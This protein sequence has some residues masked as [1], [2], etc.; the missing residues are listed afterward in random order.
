MKPKLVVATSFGVHP[1]KGGGQSRVA[2]L[3]GALARLGVEIEIVS[4]VGR[5]DRDGWIDPA[6]G[7]RELRV[8]RTPEHES[9]DWRLNQLV[10]VPIGDVG[11][12]LNHARTPAYAEAVAAC[13]ADA[14]AVVACHPY[15]LPVLEPLGLPVIYEAQDVEADLKGA[16][17]AETPDGPEL[18][19]QVREVEAACCAVAHHVLVCAARDGARLGELYGVA[20]E[21]VLEV[22][23]GADPATIPFTSLARRR[24]RVREL[25]LQDRMTALFVGS[26]HE[27]NLVAIRDLLQIAEEL[28]EAGVRVL[29]CGSAGLAFADYGIPGNI[30]L[31]GVVDDA[32]LGSLL[33][34]ADVALNPMRSGSGSNLKMLDYALGG[35]PLVSSTFGAR[36]FDVEPGT[37]YLPAEPE[38]LPTVLAAL[39][40]EPFAITETR[41]ATARDHVETR[42]SWE[43]IAAGWHASPALQSLFGPVEVP[44]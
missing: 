26:W 10:G 19:Q 18:A 12:A 36:G 43:R 7:V 8:P 1:P 17:Y 31:C 5:T 38:E 13:A 15:A 34:L 11:L 24:A 37:H 35:V 25:G 3:Y 21:R 28:D 14:Q 30:D 39:H 42:F 44:S 40:D 33:G 32:F 16:M 27:P 20:P 2:G 6:P 22:P 4:L 29:V 9:A 23:N 41:V